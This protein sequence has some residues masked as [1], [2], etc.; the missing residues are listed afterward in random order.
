MSQ[1]II[2]D[3]SAVDYVLDAFEK[4]VD[5]DGYIVESDSGEKVLTP[6]GEEILADELAIL[7]E[8]SDVFIEDNFASIVDYVLNRSE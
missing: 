3:D 8:G 4:E 7:A 2:F 1:E 5:S 6:D